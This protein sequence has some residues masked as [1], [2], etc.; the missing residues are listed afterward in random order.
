VRSK[1]PLLCALAAVA[2][3]LRI[4]PALAADDCKA[5]KIDLPVTLSG[6]RALLDAK[7]N[8]QDARFFFDSGAFY[9]TISAATAAQFGLKLSPA[10]YGMYITGMGGS[11]QVS[12]ATVKEFTLVGIP[13]RNKEFVVGGSE[14]GTESAGVLGQEIAWTFDVEYDFSHSAMRLFRIEGCKHTRLAYWLTP[15]QS[16]SLLDIEKRE[17]GHLHTIAEVYVNGKKIRAMFDTGAPKSVLSLSAAKRA[18]VALETPGVE[19]AGMSSGIGRARFE[20]YIAPFASFRVGD[21]EEIQNARLRIADAM[22]PEAD[23][24][25]GFDFFLS[26]RIFVAN[27]QRKMYISY[28]GGPVFNL[29]KAPIEIVPTEARPDVGELTDAADFARRGIRRAPRFRARACRPK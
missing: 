29:A 27:S 26:H 7:I 6:M 12:V 22:I 25:I 23:M 2:A 3:I 13:M 11:A 14:S 10:P 15:G 16:Y 17:L 4:A 19:K 9:S 21:A 20:T 18:G 8:G 24:L 5:Q 28:N 1:L